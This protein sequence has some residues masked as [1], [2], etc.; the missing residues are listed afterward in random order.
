MIMKRREPKQSSATEQLTQEGLSLKDKELPKPDPLPT[1]DKKFKPV[2]EYVV[3]CDIEKEWP[4]LER[5]MRRRPISLK[6][7][8][9]MLAEQP[10]MVMRAK[11]IE[12]LAKKELERFNLDFKERTGVLRDLAIEY[13]EERKRAGMHKQ[14]TNEMIEDWIVEHYGEAWTEMKS[15]VRDMKNAHRLL[16]RLTKQV[17]DRAANLRRDVDLFSTKVADPS[18]FTSQRD[19]KRKGK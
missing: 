6:D 19:R 7:A 12:L 14:I 9:T 13:W 3:E 1:Y 2:H 16:E 4:E 15:R 5:W 17:I 11:R 18:W 10:N 8:M